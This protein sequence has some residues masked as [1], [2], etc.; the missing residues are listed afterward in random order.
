VGLCT[1]LALASPA[2]ANT[3]KLP[4]QPVNLNSA[5]SEELQP[6]PGFGPRAAGKI[7]Q[8]RKSCGPFESVDD[9]VAIRGIGSASAR[10][11]NT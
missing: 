5:S 11:A 10:G 2:S 8:M 4:L 9:L 3:K 1:A 7:L 6:V